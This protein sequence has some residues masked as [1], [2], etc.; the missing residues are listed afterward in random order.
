MANKS[1][2][3]ALGPKTLTGGVFVAPKGTALPAD[4]TTALNVAFKDAGYVG[5]SGLTMTINK[6]NTKI[7]DWGKSVVKV[8][9]TE[10]DVQFAWEYIELNVD[11][12]KAF[13]GAANVTET[14]GKLTIKVNDATVADAVYVF[15]MAD[16]DYPVRIVVPSG[17]MAAEGGEF[18]FNRDDVL[19]IPMQIEALKDDATGNNALI[20]AGKTVTP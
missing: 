18:A 8:I 7:R 4:G 17:A 19:R 15:E 16:G 5:E 14:S 12:A 13:F 3:V 2:V 9:Q 1:N 11:S 20:Y 10:H 6:S